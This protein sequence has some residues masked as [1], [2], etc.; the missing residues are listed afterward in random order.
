MRW[1]YLLCTL[2]RPWCSPICF[3]FF[4]FHRVTMKRSN[5]IIN[6]HYHSNSEKTVFN[7]FFY[8]FFNYLVGDFH[9]LP[10]WLRRGLTL[11]AHDHLRRSD[12]GRLDCSR[13]AVQWWKYRGRPRQRARLYG[14]LVRPD[15]HFLVERRYT[16]WTLGI[17]LN[18]F[19]FRYYDR[20]SLD[21]YQLC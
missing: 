14:Q 4:N 17:T 11:V 5:F 3:H 6:N 20:C 15:A 12:C 16:R 2:I 13:S 21:K 7:L 8:F 19:S 10:P 18:A 1:R 9:R